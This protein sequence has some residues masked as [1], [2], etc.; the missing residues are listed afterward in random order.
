MTTPV[1][2]TYYSSSDPGA[3]QIVTN[4]PQTILH[5]IRQCLVGNNGMAY[6]EGKHQKKSSGWNLY[7][8]DRKNCKLVVQQG[9]GQGRY[10][11]LA[12]PQ[13]VNGNYPITN[14]SGRTYLMMIAHGFSA[15]T[16]IDTGTGSFPDQ[17]SWPWSYWTWGGGTYNNNFGAIVQMTNPIAWYIVADKQFFYIKL[18]FTNT[19]LNYWWNQGYYFGDLV[20]GY[21]ADTTNTVLWSFTESVVDNSYGSPSNSG[22]G[23]YDAAPFLGYVTADNTAGPIPSLWC[24]GSIAGT[25][26]GNNPG[27]L[28]LGMYYAGLFNNPAA[29]TLQQPFPTTAF[30]R[31][32]RMVGF[33]LFEQE[34]SQHTHYRGTLPGAFAQDNQM[35]SQTTGTI[36]EG[37]QIKVSGGSLNNATLVSWMNAT[38]TAFYGPTVLIRTDTWRSE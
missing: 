17:K 18:V 37:I 10:L 6:G 32:I 7:A 11:R 20:N 12:S 27:G 30:N 31:K 5:V 29:G 16:N 15:M 2:V 28:N 26:R 21:E 25:N 24:A 4:N 38:Q 19:G 36:P 3:P 22:Q 8:E 35:F 34:G 14:S 13:V 1:P 33:N 23:G 9:G